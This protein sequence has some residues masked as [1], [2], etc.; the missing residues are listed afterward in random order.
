[1]HCL[2]IASYFNF[3]NRIANGSGIPVETAQD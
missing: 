1:M 2:L 3:A